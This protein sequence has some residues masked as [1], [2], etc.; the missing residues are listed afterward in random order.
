METDGLA[1]A[2]TAATA[3]A[4]IV[5]IYV[6]VRGDGSDQNFRNGLSTT[7]VVQMLIIDR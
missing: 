7:L 1:T 3:I 4:A 5:E 2:A 6:G